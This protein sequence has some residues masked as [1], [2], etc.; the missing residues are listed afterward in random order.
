MNTTMVEK[1]D[2][3]VPLWLLSI[4]VTMPTFF[5]FLATSATNVA[6]PHIAGSFGSTNDEAK[7]VVTSY[8]VANGIFLPLTGWLERKFG[9]LD[10]LKIFIALFTLGSCVC[11]LATNL[12]ILILGRIIQ[13]VGGG[14]L[15]PLSQSILL[16]EF[17]KDRKSDA[18]AIF[19]FAIMVSSI[20]GPTVGGFLV[21]YFSWQWIFIINIPIGILSLIVIP[22][23]V[24][25][26]EKDHSND[27]V[28][29]LGLTF[30][31]LWLFSMQVVLDKG[32]QYGWFDCTWI[33]WLSVFSL[34]CMFF[35]VIWELEIKK[36][37][38]D[39]RVFKDLNFVIGT[40][41]GVLVNIMVCVTIILLPQYYQGLMHY[42]ASL[43][44]LALA[45]RVVACLALFVIGRLCQLYDLRLLI[46]TGF[47]CLGISISLCA[48][49]NLQSEPAAIILSNILFGIG[50]VF[51]LVP[52]SALA[53]GTLPKNK[54]PDAAGV[55]SLSKCVTGSMFT[56][57]ASS[58]SISLSQVHQTYLLKNMTV[59]NPIFVKY[60]TALK[61]VF[62]NN[63]PTLSAAKKANVVL[64]KQLLVQAKLC[65]FADLF[66][67]AAL[68][69]FMVIPLVI[70]LKTDKTAKQ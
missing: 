7:W 43:T 15:M 46:A 62:L 47:V 68:V 11:A 49:L 31:I 53:L 41:L 8:M 16:Q 48:N 54:I 38:V 14:I 22:F 5:A 6:L 3:S 25:D 29:F 56:S 10:F 34:G 18:M 70:F 12:N 39:L 42:T 52:I 55:H 2:K 21:D 69:T 61:S 65:A 51:A 37:I 57:L 44:G 20:M 58:F 64:Y 13:G 23:I 24:N 1:N 36:P 27:A 9:R 59:Y 33:C 28:D 35:F 30:L 4:V 40:I 45:S 66:Q 19:I 26:T 63:L 67:Y 60:F 17:P 50:S 32:Q